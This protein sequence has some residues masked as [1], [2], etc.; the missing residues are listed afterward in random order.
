M[1]LAP[2]KDKAGFALLRDGDRLLGLTA[3]G[4]RHATERLL[5]VPLRT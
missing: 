3:A 4:R 1:F 2:D 5:S